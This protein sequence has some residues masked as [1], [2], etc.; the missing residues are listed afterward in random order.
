MAH[1]ER[2]NISNSVSLAASLLVIDITTG[3]YSDHKIEKY[4]DSIS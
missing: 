3:A 1:L 4:S 2:R